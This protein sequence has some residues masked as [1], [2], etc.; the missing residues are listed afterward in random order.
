MGATYQLVPVALETKLYSE[1]VAKWQFAFHVI[2]FVGM[3]W[4][5]RKWDMKQVGHFGSVMAVSVALFVFNIGKTLRRATKWNVV[6]T[7]IAS[8]LGWF[9]FAVI[10]GLSIAAA[11]CNYESVEG[12]ATAEGVRTVVNGLRA[13]SAFMSNFDAINAMH[14]HAHVG[15]VGLF[16]MLIVGLSY[17]LIPMF[18][19]SE[20][21]SPRRAIM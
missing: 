15:V 2:G 1:R 8:A 11:K 9:S 12:L 14:A 20:V 5:F 21:Q 18:T 16:T 6:A 10:A 4:M 3:V 17:K 13:V 19:L 7:A